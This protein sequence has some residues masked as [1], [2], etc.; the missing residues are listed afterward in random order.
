[1]GT[2]REPFFRRRREYLGRAR[3]VGAVSVYSAAP[4]DASPLCRVAV[5]EQAEVF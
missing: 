1:M 3:Y 4:S 5:C 2:L